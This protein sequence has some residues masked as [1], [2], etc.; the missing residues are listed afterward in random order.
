M[1]ETKEHVTKVSYP[2]GCSYSNQRRDQSPTV[3]SK[4]SHC[5]IHI[6]KLNKAKIELDKVWN[7][8]LC[9]KPR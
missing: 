2:C 5:A 7:S 8:I 4:W 1:P 3:R 9:Q 6:I